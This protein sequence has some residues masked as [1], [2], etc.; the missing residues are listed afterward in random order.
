MDTVSALKQFQTKLKCKK[1][2]VNLEQLIMTTE[3]EIT[4]FEYA[5]NQ[6]GEYSI[7]KDPEYFVV[8]DNPWKRP[9]R[10]QSFKYFDFKPIDKDSC[11]SYV[12]FTT[13]R[14]LTALNELDLLFLSDRK[15][16][17]NSEFHVF[18]DPELRYLASLVQPVLQKYALGFVDQEV[19]VTGKWTKAQ[20]EDYFDTRLS[21]LMQEVP[22]SFQFIKAS[23][24]PKP[25]AE[26]LLIQHALDFLVEASHM[27]RFALGDY[28]EL[29]SQ[30]FRVL[31]DEFGYG[32][33][34]SKHSTLFK[35][36]LHSVGLNENSHAYWQFYLN[37]TLLLNNYF[38]RLTKEPCNFFKYLGA[39]TLA[40]N[41]FG[42]YCRNTANLLKYIY[43]DTVDVQYYLEYAHID[44]HHGFMM[45][46]DILLP[47]I[48][49]YGESII[50]DI[51]LGIEQT[52]YLQNLAENDL[53]EQ[54][55]WMSQKDNYAKLG[56]EIRDT[57]LNSKDDI[58]LSPL[59][60]PKAELSV[61]HVH[62]GDELC[63][64]NKGV[65]EFVSGPN[66]SIELTEGKAVVIKHN[67]L[68]GALVHSSECDYE[69]HSIGDYHRYANR[70]I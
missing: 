64:V 19:T 10:P 4:A 60:E 36:T 32:V 28:G 18:Y 59:L 29:Q 57:V 61:A 2:P 33:H 11:L 8:T 58:P 27:A 69:I 66:S 67:R 34:S 37:T 54:I 40:E 63:I 12:A 17:K 52:L 5:I 44:K 53:Y 41:T 15:L 38:H 7:F 49:R 47:A 9:V 43:G 26:L 21:S 35:N 13:N 39:V 70:T 25:A 62:D 31:L 16:G 30:L 45:Y 42:P 14:L 24:Y 6:I 20:F 50:P 22:K 55:Q 46:N 56:N 48:D 3:K 68:H 51:V 1:P 65:L 23:N